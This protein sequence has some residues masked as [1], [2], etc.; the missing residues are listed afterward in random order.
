MK[1]EPLVSINNGLVQRILRSC[2]APPLPLKG[3]ME[4]KVN[5]QRETCL[6]GILSILVIALCW[7]S[8]ANGY[9]PASWGANSWGPHAPCRD[10]SNDSSNKGS[11]WEQ[12][13]PSRLPISP[14]PPPKRRDK[15]WDGLV[16]TSRCNSLKGT[17]NLTSLR[18]I[19]NVLYF[20]LI[21]KYFDSCSSSVFFHE[22]ANRGGENQVLD[23]YRKK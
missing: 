5:P 7:V 18:I 21:F 11:W 10:S 2:T 12:T 3:K 17:D 14:V 6:L 9:H 23:I 1:W 20:I 4:D 8:A 16:L 22:L 19:P 13:A 15:L